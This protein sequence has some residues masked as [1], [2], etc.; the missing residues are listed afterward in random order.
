[1][2]QLPQARETARL[3]AE[4]DGPPP[5]FTLLHGPTGIG[6]AEVVA[7]A[8]RGLDVVRYWAAPLTDPDHRAQLVARLGAWCEAPEPAPASGRRA[9]AP[10]SPLLP[11]ADWPRIFDH[12]VKRAAERHGTLRLVLEEFPRLVEA[13]SKLP[14][15]LEKFWGRVRAQGLPVHLVL[16]GRDGP[17]FQALRREGGTLA[18]WIGLDLALQPLGYREVASLFPA[19]APSDRLLAWGIFG[20]QR[21]HL[22]PCDPGVALSTNVRAVLLA[23]ESPFLLEGT[24]RLQLDLQSP[25]RYASLLAALARGHREWGEILAGAPTFQSGGQMAPYLARLQGLG[26]VS[27]EASLDALP[28][29]RQRRYRIADPFYA[30]WYRF[31]LPNLTELMAGRARDVWRTRVR[32]H[33]DAYA[34]GLFPR[35]CAEYLGEHARGRLGATAREVGGLW[36]SEYDLAPAGTLGNGAAFYGR[37]LWGGGPVPAT[38]DEALSAEMR[39]TR[40]GFGRERRIRLV[41]ATD[42]FSPELVRRAARSELLHLL[43]PEEL[44]GG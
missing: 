44:L 10:E 19:H 6:K 13:R 22:R 31:V 5:S 21:R 38:A 18:A 25:A 16:T 39:R 4:L 40:Y 12:L 37:A 35:I 1:M 26:L 24:E 9:P 2:L 11:G 28:G 32:P 3:R 7:S 34:A 29:A 17:V 33:L 42:G 23:P 8:A 20:G 14:L 41:F 27:S 15:E 43:G 36:G 30:F